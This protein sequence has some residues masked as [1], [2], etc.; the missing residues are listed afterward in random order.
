ML[1]L[2]SILWAF[3]LELL[4]FIQVQCPCFSELGLVIYRASVQLTKANVLPVSQSAQCKL[5][6]LLSVTSYRPG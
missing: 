5:I 1:V 6:H 3:H 4:I 2:V